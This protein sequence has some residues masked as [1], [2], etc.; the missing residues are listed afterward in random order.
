MKST[1]TANVGI[2][3]L[4]LDLGLN[5]RAYVNAVSDITE[6]LKKAGAGLIILPPPIQPLRDFI[7]GKR[8][9][10]SYK[11]YLNSLLSKLLDVS[12]KTHYSILVS[13]VLKRAGNRLYMT[14]ALIKPL[15]EI[16]FKGKKMVSYANA[17]DVGRDVEL[18]DLGT[19][20]LC[21]LILND[22]EYSELARVCALRGAD[23]IISVQPP[24]L[25]MMNQEVLISL[26]I[27]RAYENGIPLISLGGY[28]GQ[29]IQQPTFFIKS[30]GSI[31]DMANTF[32]VD[33][34]VAEIP[35]KEVVFAKE[36]LARKYI[37]LFNDIKKED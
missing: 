31:A 35:R 37:K 36:A 29:V 18:I 4:H 23:V 2:A 17:I 16:V 7:V 15:R 1:K 9:F 10:Q 14:S 28:V 19:I 24:T 32:E 6:D 30:D 34:F 13:P 27:S 3:V 5:S 20:R 12:S 8:K 25:T 26:S 33:A 22:I 11:S 21:N